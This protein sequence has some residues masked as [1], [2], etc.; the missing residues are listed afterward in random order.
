M[1]S[2]AGGGQ[3]K[4]G[5][6]GG[7]YRKY[8]VPRHCESPALVQTPLPETLNIVGRH[9]PEFCDG[10]KAQRQDCQKK[11]FPGITTQGK[12]T[13]NHGKHLFSLVI[14]RFKIT[15]EKKEIQVGILTWI[16]MKSVSIINKYNRDVHF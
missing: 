12:R 9:L 1:N 15:G 13:V 4:D 8:P 2:P 14:N 5:Q 3:G 10:N 7:L 11:Q 16:G 6:S